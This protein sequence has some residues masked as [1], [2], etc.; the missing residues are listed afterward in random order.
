MSDVLLSEVQ[1]MLTGISADIEHMA[2][3]TGSQ[4]E[5]VMNALDDIAAH[6]IAMQAILVTMM[7]TTAVDRDEVAAWIRA[8]RK[9]TDATGDSA[10][11]AVALADFL[12]GPP[13][14]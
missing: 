7:K 13:K 2:S 9:G 10:A 5:T 4:V 14:T 8:Q 1:K 6:T 11:K 12:I 3:V